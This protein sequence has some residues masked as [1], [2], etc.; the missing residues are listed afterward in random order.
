MPVLPEIRALITAGL[1]EVH[2]SPKFILSTERRRAIYGA[3]CP[4]ATRWTA[5]QPGS[6]LAFFERLRVA[7]EQGLPDGFRQYAWLMVLTARSALLVLDQFMAQVPSTPEMGSL[8]HLGGLPAA[9]LNVAERVISNDIDLDEVFDLACDEFHFGMAGVN[10]AF[11]YPVSCAALAASAALDM[12][13]LGYRPD[14]SDVAR[15]AVEAHTSIDENAP[16]VWSKSYFPISLISPK[17]YAHYSLDAET[18]ADR[19]TGYPSIYQ[20]PLPIRYDLN[21]R[22]Q[23]WEWWLTEAIPKAWTRAG[24]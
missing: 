22:L 15:L 2:Q 11:S 3:L 19:K 18:V 10:H 16:G 5:Q 14:S 17:D 9:I 20:P 24:A 12:I 1:E 23:F 21:K 8:H 13:C 4:E 6:Q 7:A